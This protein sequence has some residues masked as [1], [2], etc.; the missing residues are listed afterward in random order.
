MG[1]QADDIS[2]LSQKKEWSGLKAILLSHNKISNAERVVYIEEQYFISSL[3]LK[4]EQIVRAVHG[5]WMVESLSQV[6]GCDIS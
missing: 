1:T 4:I 6:F 2:W 3:Q 5:H